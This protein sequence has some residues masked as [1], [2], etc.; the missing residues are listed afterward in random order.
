MLKKDYVLRQALINQTSYG[1][2]AMGRMSRGSEVEGADPEA[3]QGRRKE[4]CKPPKS[5]C[6]ARIPQ[7]VG[8]GLHENWMNKEYAGGAT[9]R[10]STRKGSGGVHRG[11]HALADDDLCKCR[12]RSEGTGTKLRWGRGKPAKRS[13][14][15]QGRMLGNKVLGR[16]GASQKEQRVLRH[17]SEV[18]ARAKGGGGGEPEEAGRP[19][20]DGLRKL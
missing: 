7:N 4:G 12:R 19:P 14:A 1:Y 5:S 13:E 2:W 15:Q 16:K 11:G 8:R 6:F 18:P 10:R 9:L 20:I 3:T 17:G